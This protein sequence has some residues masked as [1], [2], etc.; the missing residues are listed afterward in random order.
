MKVD[1]FKVYT[2]TENT[3]GILTV[4]AWKD[5]GGV[6]WGVLMVMNTI[7]DV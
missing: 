3:V 5:R 6:G 7:V 2:Q 1:S 4:H